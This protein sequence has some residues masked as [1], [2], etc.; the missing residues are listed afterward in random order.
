MP[1]DEVVGFDRTTAGLLEFWEGCEFVVGFGH[2]LLLSWLSHEDTGFPAYQHKHT[3][4]VL[5]LTL[6]W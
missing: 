4:H 6:L 1:E 2:E 3:H 5:P